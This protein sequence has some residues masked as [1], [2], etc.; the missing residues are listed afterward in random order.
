MLKPAFAVRLRKLAGAAHDFERGAK[1]LEKIAAQADSSGEYSLELARLQGD[2]AQA[3][4]TAG[5]P[6][7]ALAHLR[8]AHERHPELLDITLRMSSLQ[9]ERGD[10]QGA[11][12][13]LQSF[14]AVAKVPAE[15]EQAKA[16]LAKLRPGG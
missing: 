15:I 12:E 2:W 6:D 7:A 16:Q 13:T 8:T 3:E 10:R 11:I 1:L 5:R 9:Q 14:L 4:Q